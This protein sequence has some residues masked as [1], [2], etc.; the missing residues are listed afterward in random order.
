MAAA[1]MA[2]RAQLVAR[3]LITAAAAAAVELILPPKHRMPLVAQ[4]ARA[5]AVPAVMVTPGLVLPEQSTLAVV[6]VVAL[7]RLALLAAQAVLAAPAW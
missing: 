6:A 3:Q 7:V 5:A 2:W 4:A 1:A